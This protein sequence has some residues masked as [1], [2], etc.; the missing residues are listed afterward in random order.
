MQGQSVLQ[1]ISDLA[2]LI[3][4]GQ[5]GGAG[6]AEVADCKQE[7]EHDGGPRNATACGGTRNVTPVA[8]RAAHTSDAAF[9]DSLVSTPALPFSTD[10]KHVDKDST[11]VAGLS[12]GVVSGQR[13]CYAL[14]PTAAGLSSRVFGGRRHYHAFTDTDAHTVLLGA[15]E[16][17]ALDDDT[18]AMHRAVAAAGEAAP[19]AAFSYLDTVRDLD[20]NDP[21][22][23]PHFVRYWQSCDSARTRADYECRQAEFSREL[24]AW[25]ERFPSLA[26][27]ATPTWADSHDGGL[28]TSLNVAGFAVVVTTCRPPNRHVVFN[29]DG[30]SWKVRLATAESSAAPHLPSLASAAIIS[31]VPYVVDAGD[32][33]SSSE[34]QHCFPGTAVAAKKVTGLGFHVHLL[35]Q[36]PTESS[37]AALPLVAPPESTAV[38]AA[39]RTAV[40]D[41]LDVTRDIND[42]V[43]ASD[44]EEAMCQKGFPHAI[45]ASMAVFRN[46]VLGVASWSPAELAAASTTGF[47]LD[48]RNGEVDVTSQKKFEG[49][50]YKR[51]HG[52]KFRPSATL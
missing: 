49:R 15:K 26:R 36:I 13:R 17:W 50:N 16:P 2:G 22:L 19:A 11:R 29:I 6:Q 46:L 48:T 28:R 35:P 39:L 52:A 8:V 4:V 38:D 21:A 51:L 5:R 34:A 32:R 7:G 14:T 9:A 27:H 37:V 30:A 24:K 3:S 44:F 41:L 23:L 40:S 10:R 45:R 43:W 25:L 12:S 31:A 20:V 18:T 42:W 33:I 1:F 47:K